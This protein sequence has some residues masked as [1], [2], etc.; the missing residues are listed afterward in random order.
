MKFGQVL[1]Y[2][3]E[4]IFLQKYLA[5]NGA[6]RLIPDLFFFFKKALLRQKQAVCSL[7]LYVSI[8]LNLA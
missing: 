7:V 3:K 4:N 5:E 2:N 6:G 1:K 8:V